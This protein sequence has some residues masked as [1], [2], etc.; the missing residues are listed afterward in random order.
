MQDDPGDHEQRAVIAHQHQPTAILHLDRH[1]V[2]AVARHVRVVG[3]QA[4]L[5]FVNLAVQPQLWRDGTNAPADRVELAVEQAVGVEAAFFEGLAGDQ[6]VVQLFAAHVR[7]Q[8]LA[9][10][11]GMAGKFVQV[12]GHLEIQHPHEDAAP[13]H[14]QK[15]VQRQQAAGRGAPALRRVQQWHSRSPVPYGSAATGRGSRFSC[16]GGRCAHRSGWC[17]GRSDSP[18]LPR[19]SSSA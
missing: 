5:E 8:V 6:R 2:A 13:G 15:A 16:A 11:H 12:A 9:L 10:Q 4:A 1:R 3:V 19:K 17:P 18:R 7:E 14:E